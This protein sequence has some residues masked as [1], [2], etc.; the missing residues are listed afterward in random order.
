MLSRLGLGTTVGSLPLTVIATGGWVLAFFGFAGITILRGAEAILRGSIFRSGYEV[1]YTPV[2]PEDKRSVKAIIDVC[3]ERVGDMVGSGI[4]TLLLI[5]HF[6]GKASI[7]GL[8]IGFSALG[9]VLC[10]RLE[11]S[12]SGAL[13]TSLRKQAVRL[14]PE[15]MLEPAF[16]DFGAS[17]IQVPETAALE[18]ESV[19]RRTGPALRDPVL[20]EL[21]DLRS[22][23]EGLVIRTLS[24]IQ[25]PHPLV[26]HQLIEFLAHDR[27]AF[28]VMDH[29]KRAAGGHVG[30]FVDTLLAGAEPF[31][32]RKR[33]PLILAGTD[34]Q[35]ALDQLLIALSDAEFVIRYRCAHAMTQIHHNHPEL[36]LSQDRIWNLV[37][38]ELEVD[39]DVWE[40]RRLLERPAAVQDD[41]EELERPG[42][43]SLEYL[44]VLLGLV[45]PRQPVS[46][47]FRALQTDDRHLRGT[48]LEYLQTVLPAHAWK[49]LE[50][51]IGEQPIRARPAKPRAAGG[52]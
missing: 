9:L 44:F 2:A 48:A 27:Y 5:L 24:R 11:G 8:A 46:V 50:G 38:Q 6:S 12:Y 51:L 7:L 4:L 36:Y 40:S 16:D 17:A 26:V 33:I 22:E 41:D 47:A 19:Q 3:G 42:D 15:P 20:A 25:E 1:L 43:A 39:V 28:F 37:N 34:S 32:I 18:T 23:D 13:E 31:A 29:L 30:Q 35:R 45:L 10:R 21:T 49:S 14:A 52:T